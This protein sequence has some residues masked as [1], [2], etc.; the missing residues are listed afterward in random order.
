VFDIASRA[1]LLARAVLSRTGPDGRFSVKSSRFD[2][3]ILVGGY[4][5]ENTNQESCAAIFLESQ[6]QLRLRIAPD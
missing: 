6:Q 4:G 1:G 5:A 2:V 3:Q